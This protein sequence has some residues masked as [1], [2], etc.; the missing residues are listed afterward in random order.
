VLFTP[1]PLSA[2]SPAACLPACCREGVVVERSDEEGN[3]TVALI[4]RGLELMWA[5]RRWRLCV[6]RACLLAHRGHTS[7]GVGVASLHRLAAA[8]YLLCGQP[9]PRH[10]RIATRDGCPANCLRRNLAAATVPLYEAAWQRLLAEAR[11][12]PTSSL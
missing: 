5:Q 7:S 2:P 1:G 4:E 9:L 11:L 10:V 3:T 8:H 12:R 6:D